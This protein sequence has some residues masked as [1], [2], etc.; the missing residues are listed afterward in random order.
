M[1]YRHQK[2]CLQPAVA[3]IVVLKGVPFEDVV[4]KGEHHGAILSVSGNAVVQSCGRGQTVTHDLR[5]LNAP[6]KEGEPASIKYGADGKGKVTLG[7]DTGK[8]RGR[9]GRRSGALPRRERGAPVGR[10]PILRLRR[11]VS[12][13]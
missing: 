5:N 6:V 8:D 1:V 12:G 7:R 10:A 9:L 3:T 2:R 4:T 13:W 11:G